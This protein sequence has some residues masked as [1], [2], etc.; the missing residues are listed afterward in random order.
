MVDQALWGVMI[1]SSKRDGW[2]PAD[3]EARIAAFTELSATAI[4]NAE[5]RARL[6]RLV[7]EQ[8]ALRRVATL[9]A[10]GVPPERVF[11]AVIE[12]AGRLI[13]VEFAAMARYESDDTFTVIATSSAV[14]DAFP[15]GGR[16]PIGGNN[17]T[18]LVFETGRPARI[19]D[20]ADA[21]GPVG[22][23][24]RNEGAGSAVGAPIVVDGHLWG[25]TA[26]HSR[27]G[28]SLPADTESRL[29]SFTELV[30]TAVANA[31]S[32]AALAASRARI[33]VAADETRK[34]IERDLHDGT[35]QRLIS[36]GLE[37]RAARAIVPPQLG[38]LEGGL[39]Q[40]A[41]GLTSV[42]D[43][44][45]EIARGIH[46]AI[47]S[48]GGLGPAIRALCRRSVIPVELDLHGD[49]RLPEPVE[50][51]AYYVVSEGLTN[52]AKH[53]NPSAVKVS[54]DTHATTLQLAIRDDGIGGA[55]PSD[56]SGLVGLRDRIEALGGTFR[57][58][59]PA[60]NGT[61][62]LIKVPLEAPHNTPQPA[63]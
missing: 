59:S 23:A 26:A 3:T 61:S 54:L 25:V 42:S 56:G 16:W 21:S 45:R 50:V 55:D 39:S 63:P 13:P 4:A 30:A 10:L 18:S 7:E 41:E 43:E 36:L 58:T 31:E 14:G 47:L 40:V 20:Y 11:T 46:P 60:G 6:T 34:R 37:L 19:D 24:V 52:A 2:L 22:E 12:E 35:Q 27:P 5:S 53:A 44:L 15:V 1:A 8:T 38:E 49:R 62:L 33:V 17:V 48:E 51:A 32:R 29:A 9:V 57:V 28:Q